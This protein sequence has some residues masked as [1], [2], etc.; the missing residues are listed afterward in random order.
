MNRIVKQILLLSVACI[1]CGAVVLGGI[2]CSTQSDSSPCTEVCIVIEDSLER[3]FV[4]VNELEA[5]M[6]EL[7]LSSVLGKQ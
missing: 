3:Q 7:K 5:L 4:D 2:W 6:Q 1:C